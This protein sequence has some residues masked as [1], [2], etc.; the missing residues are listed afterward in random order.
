MELR[1]RLFEQLAMEGGEEDMVEIIHKET[2]E[3]SV[4]SLKIPLDKAYKKIIFHFDGIVCSGDGDIM[5]MADT[6]LKTWNDRCLAKL[7]KGAT[8]ANYK[9]SRWE[10]DMFGGMPILSKGAINSSNMMN[11][12]MN[13]FT[14]CYFDTEAPMEY[15]VILPGSDDITIDSG[16]IVIYGVY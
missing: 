10:I 11:A 14:N 15:M 8:T 3:K 7:I 13:Y 12:Q 9:Y 5:I 4:S 2:I 1:R 6:E 16:N